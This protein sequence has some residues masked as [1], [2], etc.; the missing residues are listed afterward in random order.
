M[1]GVSAPVEARHKALLD[2]LPDLLLR[3]RADGTY[4]EIGGDTSKLANPPDQVVGSN[5]HELLPADVADR[6]MDCVRASLEQ[7]KLA[8]VEVYRPHTEAYKAARKR[9]DPPVPAIHAWL[10]GI[11]ARYSHKP[12]EF[13]GKIV[14][15]HSTRRSDPE[16]GDGYLVSLTIRLDERLFVRIEDDSLGAYADSPELARTT[17]TAPPSSGRGPPSMMKPSSTRLSMKAACS[18]Q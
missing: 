7:G 3:L 13:A 11:A 18:S 2:A 16:K 14:R 1:E 17:S 12:E 5:A 6:L 15:S 9:G 4:L 10:A 8:T